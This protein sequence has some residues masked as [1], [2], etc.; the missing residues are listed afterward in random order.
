LRSKLQ[1]KSLWLLSH[2]RNA[3]AHGVKYQAETPDKQP[4]EM[5]RPNKGSNDLFNREKIG[6]TL[7]WYLR[8]EMSK[9]IG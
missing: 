6:A 2:P 1:D 8:N 4:A 9:Y 3:P 5:R 7:M